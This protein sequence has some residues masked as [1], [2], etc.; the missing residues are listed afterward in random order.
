VS[1][2]DL[3]TP[4]DHAGA[5]EWAAVA[6]AH[7]AIGLALVAV[8]A[9]MITRAAPWIDGRGRLALVIV[10]T[11]YLLGWEIG[12]QAVGAGWSDALLDTAMV[13]AGGALGVLAWQRRGGGIAAVLG[14]VALTLWAGIKERAKK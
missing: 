7:V 12:V 8:I 4:T 11:A 1:G 3:L 6:L 14:G 9:A 13:A 5:Y 10:A 2:L